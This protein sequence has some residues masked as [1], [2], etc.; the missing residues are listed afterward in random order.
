MSIDL[1]EQRWAMLTNKQ[2]GVVPEMTRASLAEIV[3]HLDSVVLELGSEFLKS[4]FC[5]FSNEEHIKAKL[6]LEISRKQCRKR[7]MKFCKYQWKNR[8]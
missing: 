5:Q 4:V 1:T 7:F 3:D 8:S 6:K 2:I